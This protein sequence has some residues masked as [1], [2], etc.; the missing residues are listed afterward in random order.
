[1]RN[2]SISIK[3][4][5]HSEINRLFFKGRQ[6]KTNDHANSTGKPEEKDELEE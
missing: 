4:Q 6:K 1:M 3:R 5:E 2:E